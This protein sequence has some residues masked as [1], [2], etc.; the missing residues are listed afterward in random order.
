MIEDTAETLDRRFIINFL[1]STILGSLCHTQ[2]IADIHLVRR[3]YRDERETARTLVKMMNSKELYVSLCNYVA[4]V[5]DHSPVRVGSNSAFLLVCAH[6]FF[7][8]T[9]NPATASKARPAVARSSRSV[10]CFCRHACAAVADD[11]ALDKLR[12]SRST[13]LE[14]N[15]NS[16]IQPVD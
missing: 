14:A 12:C 6:P 1:G 10:G 11:N 8:G 3:W 4:E 15:A 2:T 13:A 16:A 7:S 5:F 9:P